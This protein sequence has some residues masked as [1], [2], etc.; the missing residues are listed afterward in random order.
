MGVN[1]SIE[2]KFNENIDFSKIINLL[3]KN[4]WYINDYGRLSY[5]DNDDYDWKETDLKNYKDILDKLETRLKKDKAI[6]INLLYE[7]YYGGS[8]TFLDNTIIFNVNINRKK[9]K[10]SVHTDFSF[11]LSK[12][13]FMIKN[14]SIICYEKP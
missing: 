3:L 8:F 5:M 4:N 12:L 9:I 14:C 7:K 6:S 1:A 13:L 11:Y 10:D 2:I